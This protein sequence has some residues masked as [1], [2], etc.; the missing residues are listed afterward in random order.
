MW[1]LHKSYQYENSHCLRLHYTATFKWKLQVTEIIRMWGEGHPPQDTRIAHSFT[2]QIDLV[3]HTDRQNT[4][5]PKL[6]H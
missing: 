1:P 5:V 2:G 3:T 6:A 4:H